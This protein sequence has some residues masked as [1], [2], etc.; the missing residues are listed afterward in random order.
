MENM[1]MMMARQITRIMKKGITFQANRSIFR[2][3]VG[4]ARAC[5]AIAGSGSIFGSID[6]LVSI[7]CPYYLKKITTQKYV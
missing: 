1:G 6:G 5:E 2:I 4:F 3:I 7:A